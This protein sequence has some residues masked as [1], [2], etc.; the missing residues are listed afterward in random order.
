MTKTK[1][2]FSFFLLPLS[3]IGLIDSFAIHQKIYGGYY[4]PCVIGK[5]CD[6]VLYS[7]Y[8][9]LF[10]VHLSYWGIAF[11]SFIFLLALLNIFFG[12]KF[13]RFI[14]YSSIFAGM[15]FSLYLL[16]LQIFLIGNLCVYCVVSFSDILLASVLSSLVIFNK[17]KSF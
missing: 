17:N 4:L 13:L 8:S 9:T 1:K 11:Y 5:S 6:I 16:Y 12:K 2:Y 14:Y 15:I 10:G 7:K 3:L